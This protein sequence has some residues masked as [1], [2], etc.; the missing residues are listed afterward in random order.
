M[1]PLDNRPVT[2]AFPCLLAEAAGMEA[3]MPPRDMLGS[4]EQPAR[5]AEMVAWIE[6]EIAAVKPA[7]LILCLDTILYGG[8]VHSRR[9]GEPPCAINSRL[10][11]LPAW[12]QQAGPETIILAQASIMRI[13]DSFDASEEMPYWSRFGRQIYSWSA[14][15][16]KLSLSGRISARQLAD[17]EAEIPFEIRQDYLERRRKNF[18]INRKL[19]ALVKD[20]IIDYLALSADDSGQY[21]LNVKERAMLAREIETL[22]LASRASVY[23]GADEVASTLVARAL[24]MLAKA[25]PVCRTFFADE[26]SRDCL[27]K[28][29]GQPLGT[30][31]SLHLEAAGV[32]VS[33]R[34]EPDLAIVVH[35]TGKQGDYIDTGGCQVEAKLDTGSAVAST[36]ALIEAAPAAVVLIDLA[37][38]NGADPALVEALLGNQA[39][40]A[41]IVAYAGWNT[42]GNSIGSAVAQGVAFWYNS[43]ARCP[44][45]GLA[46]HLLKECLF[47]RLADDWAYQASIRPRLSGSPD[48][49]KLA[50]LMQPFLQRIADSLGYRPGKIRV[51]FPWQRTFEIEIETG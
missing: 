19:I 23:P 41:R 18:L 43:I 34:Q 2:G 15:L 10:A 6:N 14:L 35:A 25:N 45:K 12:R 50:M 40:L 7:A 3:L 17:L 16:H 44:D 4:L 9:C 1:V 28:Y 38:A 21:G 13:A 20:Q 46:N 27:G 29:E 51:A 24:T 30:T 32:R 26:A 33:Q 31:L 8:L 36:L 37:F 47:V 48:Q 42:A 5:T 39:L 11:R 22:K 49:A